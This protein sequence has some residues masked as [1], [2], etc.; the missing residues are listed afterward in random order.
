MKQTKKTSGGEKKV[1]VRKKDMQPTKCLFV[2]L[3]K[4]GGLLGDS[5]SQ[6]PEWIP[7]GSD[8]ESRVV[9]YQS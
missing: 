6:D 8:H 3:T 7:G 1:S 4:H 5:G 9:A 2:M